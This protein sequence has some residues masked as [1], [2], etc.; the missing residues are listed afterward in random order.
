MKKVIQ[1]MLSMFLV[2]SSF[3]ITL[4]KASDTTQEVKQYFKTVYIYL[5]SDI[6]EQC[7]LRAVRDENKTEY[8]V[9]YFDEQHYSV[10]ALK[11]AKTLS[12]FIDDSESGYNELIISLSDDYNVY[13]ISK[14]FEDYIYRGSNVDD[15]Y[16]IY[17]EGNYYDDDASGVGWEYDYDNYTL[18]LNNAN[19]NM[20][21]EHAL[22][23]KGPLNIVL[24]DDSVNTIT[25]DWYG[26]LSD[27]YVQISGN[28]SLKIVSN[29]FYAIN[30]EA[31][32]IKDGILECSANAYTTLL[33]QLVVGDHATIRIKATNEA[34][35]LNTT[36][37]LYN[38]SIL[39]INEE[40]GKSHVKG[41]IYDSS[42]RVDSS[43]FDSINRIQSSNTS[44]LY[45]YKD[46]E[47]NYTKA[48]VVGN[49]KLTRELTV[50][51]LNVKE[52]ATLYCG[53]GYLNAE[54]IYN[55][56]IIVTSENEY[57]KIKAR[58]A[59]QK[60]PNVYVLGEDIANGY[61][62][63]ETY[64]TYFTCGENGYALYDYENKEIKLYDCNI[65]GSLIIDETFKVYDGTTNQR[66]GSDEITNLENS[67]KLYGIVFERNDLVIKYP[68]AIKLTSD[69]ELIS[70][71]DSFK[72][73]LNYA[74]DDLV[75][76][77]WYENEE[78]IEGANSEELSV[79]NK[80]KGDYQYK[81]EIK[82][83]DYSCQYLYYVGVDP[84]YQLV[85]NDETFYFVESSEAFEKAKS[86]EE[87]T[88][89]A[90]KDIEKEI[91][92]ANDQKLTLNMNGYDM[93]NELLV[94]EK[95]TFD[96][97][98]ES[99]EVSTMNY[100]SYYGDSKGS[101]H[102]YLEINYLL[103][104]GKQMLNVKDVNVGVASIQ[105]EANVELENVMLEEV[106]LFDQANCTIKDSYISS[107]EKNIEINKD[108]TLKL[109]GCGFDSGINKIVNF[110]MLY[111][112][113][114][115]DCDQLLITGDGISD[116][117]NIGELVKIELETSNY[118]NVSLSNIQKYE[119]SG[120]MFDY[121]TFSD[122]Y[123]YL[124]DD[125]NL[126]LADHQNKVGAYLID[127]NDPLK[128]I[129]K[130]ICNEF[131]AP[132]SKCVD[133]EIGVSKLQSKVYDNQ[134]IDLVYDPMIG[135]DT[136]YIVKMVKEVDGKYQEVQEVKDAGKY[137]VSLEMFN[138]KDE[139]IRNSIVQEVEIYA[140]SLTIKTKRELQYDSDFELTLDDIV[141]EGLLPHDQVTKVEYTL[142]GC[143]LVIDS[144]VVIDESGNDV[145]SNYVFEQ[146]KILAH[147]ENNITTHKKGEACE[148]CGKQ[149]GDPLS[150]KVINFED[151]KVKDWFY[152]SVEDA[153]NYGL[154][155]NTGKGAT[156]F[157]PNEPITRG[158]VATVL[159]RMAGKPS[160]EFKATFKDVTNSKLWYASAI[161]WASQNNVVS[162][163]KDGNFG[164]DDY[165]TRQD[166]AI[167]LRNFAKANGL[168]TN[169]KVDF[170]AFKD[171]N[172]VVSYAQSAVAFCTN[173][174]LMS[175]AKKADG[176]YLNP[177]DNATRAECAKMFSLLY[178]MIIS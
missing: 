14:V 68:I 26:I 108:S 102:D 142:N 54:N 124:I 164:P 166:L 106:I 92:Y 53:E 170:S 86:Y 44:T 76:I 31:L 120:N 117:E 63:K 22:H 55:Q 73:S 1:F 134:S 144:I 129:G 41:Y 27:S 98:N 145:S 91:T 158:M 48:D 35:A 39:D 165:I 11:D 37:Y 70:A 30:T 153:Y 17:I 172:K 75:E 171:G 163:Y 49:V 45:A 116:V 74:F 12:L 29:T 46:S 56:G 105:N 100:V 7:F 69:K 140:R 6:A 137:Q 112:E 33:S 9:I 159:Y 3:N 10:I 123:C 81:C 99:D 177:T 176:V 111:L 21:D 25:T 138:I 136:E 13:T 178:E 148:Y 110:G 66:L 127:S 93:P 72:L 175:G 151:V 60:Q 149:L 51:I 64:D 97:V 50:P 107:G 157:E 90:L 154:M 59:D 128:M 152:S 58:A 168:D 87:S 150:K 118:G 62:F 5:D 83:R 167:M 47:G 77:V 132:C 4:I 82:S 121:I 133:F 104:F 88:L 24:A 2:L 78:V 8:E 131:D 23:C 15:K 20:L 38:N 155:A 16:G 18:T 173:A 126:K 113:G 89:I 80:E 36:L 84:N 162:G 130:V 135:L 147:K 43:Y 125:H 19:F 95:G 52:K 57:E 71:N 122:S 174:K 143:E 139:T 141:V 169:V 156:F 96:I 40:Q 109:I 28:G 114:D 61:E 32:S 67:D 161:T 119:E 94:V 85:A 42:I 146:D 103:S 115:I 79:S 101:I 65:N 160:V 34:D